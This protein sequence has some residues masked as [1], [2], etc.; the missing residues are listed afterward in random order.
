MRAGVK[1]ELHLRKF[2]FDAPLLFQQFA[3]EIV[4][5]LRDNRVNMDKSIIILGDENGIN[6][7]YARQ[8]AA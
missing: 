4:A 7:L 2:S 6:F 1:L 3:V 8:P 5:V